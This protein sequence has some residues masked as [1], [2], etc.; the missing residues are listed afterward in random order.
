[1]AIE[2][3][4]PITFTKDSTLYGHSSTDEA[5]FPVGAGNGK[6]SQILDMSQ[7]QTIGSLKD[8][9]SF[10]QDA[11]DSLTYH[12]N[13]AG[14]SV[15]TFAVPPDK[16]LKTVTFDE[17]TKVLSFT[18]ITGEGTESTIPVNLSSL[19][20]TYRAGNG[21][22]LSSGVFSIK[23]TSTE[24]RLTLSADGLSF[25]ATD[26]IQ[27]VA[28]EETRAQS[29]ESGLLNRVGYIEHTLTLWKSDLDS[30]RQSAESSANSAD[31]YAKTA[32]AQAT[33]ATEQATNASNS[34]SR[35]SAS[36]ANAQTSANTAKGYADQAQALVTQAGLNIITSIEQTVSSTESSGKNTI[37][38]TQKN[39]T[40]STFDVYNGAQGEQG[41]QGLKGDDALVYAQK[42]EGHISVGEAF[43][44]HRDWFNRT[45]K[46][47]EGFRIMDGEGGTILNCVID[48]ATGNKIT[49][50]CISTNDIT[51]QQG[52][53]GVSVSS[54][55]Q[56]TTSTASSG[57]NVI[58][59]TL[60][61]GTK[62][63]FKVYNGAQGDNGKS[64]IIAQTTYSA[65]KSALKQWA[66]MASD[67]YTYQSSS[68]TIKVGDTVGFVVTDTTDNSPALVIRPVTAI[69]SDTNVTTGAGTLITIGEKGADGTNG[70]NGTNG[71]DGDDKVY[72]GSSAPSDSKYQIW[73]NPDGILNVKD[74]SGNWVD[75]TSL[76]AY[77]KD[78]VNA[79]ISGKADASHTHSKSQITDFAHTHHMTFTEI[80]RYATTSNGTMT[81][82]QSILNFDFIIIRCRTTWGYWYPA[83]IMQSTLWSEHATNTNRFLATTDQ[84]YVEL[85]FTSVTGLHIAGSNKNLIIVYGVSIGGSL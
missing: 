58:T 49:C 34:A 26:L 9:I 72:V 62:S 10:T 37:S 30:Y 53:Q 19:I 23:L 80:G 82:N 56:T 1:M 76:D 59:A 15:A 8:S 75:I 48:D 27:L 22:A 83:T 57:E 46:M 54:V 3:N 36:E 61:D 81:L 50:I 68:D 47:G 39:G 43:E 41:I 78:E 5:G 28:D 77:T 4:K 79:M 70:T 32:Q 67:N 40:V 44:L 69:N 20:D 71:K 73:V 55:E 16:F 2:Y 29:A 25:D 38:I 17:S 64:F 13:I 45:P 60:S 18:F 42:A 74:S 6:L 24:T 21:L 33:V 66:S 11:S 84:Q 12:L 31:N 52:P 51:G 65:T 85:Y 63:T 14:E 7:E 35:A